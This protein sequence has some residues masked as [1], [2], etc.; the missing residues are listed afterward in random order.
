MNLGIT[1]QTALVFAKIAP[2]VGAAAFVAA[3]EAGGADGG[4]WAELWRIGISSALAVFISLVGMIYQNMNRRLNILE[5][6]AR[7]DFV[8]HREY[9]GRH[10]DLKEQLDRI[11]RLMERK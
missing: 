4:P 1:K 5:T 9:E 11:E 3:I 2:L 10:N 6:A 7:D 8:S